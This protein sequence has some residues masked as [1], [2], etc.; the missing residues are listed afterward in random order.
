VNRSPKHHWLV[1]L[2][3]IYGVATQVSAQSFSILREFTSSQGSPSARLTL[4]SNT[5]YGTTAGTVFKVNTDGTS[6]T[7]LHNYD[8]PGPAGPRTLVL[9][10]S[11]LYG[12]TADGNLYVNYGTI[13][14][15]Q[16]D[17]TGYTNLHNFFWGDGAY[18]EGG[19]V[20][21]GKTLYG[22]THQG[23][24]WTNGTLFAINTDGTGFTNLHFFQSRAIA[25]DGSFAHGGVLLSSN[26]LYGTAERGGE[27][28]GGVVYAFDTNGTS[29]TNIHSF[30][31]YSG[32]VTN[33]DGLSPESDVILSGNTVYGTTHD[34]GSFGGGSVFKVNIDG[35]GF[36]NLHSF[37]GA[38]S[39]TNPPTYSTTNADGAHPSAGLIL[40][41]DTL[42]GAAGDGGLYANGTLFSLRTDGTGFTVRHS[43]TGGT[44]GAQPLAGLVASGH[45]LYGGASAGGAFGNGTLF[46]ISFAPQLAIDARKT[47]AVLTWPTNYMGFDYSGFGL[48]S[49]TNL[50]SGIWTASPFTPSVVNGQKVVTNPI[51]GTE[52]FFR[53]R[54]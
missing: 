4:S 36:T 45:A 40:V 39:S 47:N 11:T 54:Q 8:V 5:L 41:G 26:I 3:A 32:Y 23:G 51:S 9:S 46:T 24:P 13:F 30:R 33:E 28:D 29:Y 18:P 43:F 37:Q 48:Q 20:L 52:Q 21:S 38:G 49:T 1:P 14:A 27:W 44:D 53:L 50:A 19:L 34:G 42:F 17:G 31:W 12:T 22:S 6:F 2:L 25:T 15:L 35:T 10:G 16:T 7:T